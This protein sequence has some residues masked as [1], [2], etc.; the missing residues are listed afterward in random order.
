MAASIT[1]MTPSAGSPYGGQ[2]LTITGTGFGSTQGTGTITVG[3]LSAPVVSWTATEVKATTP[4]RI[5]GDGKLVTT[6]GSVSVVLTGN[7]TA[8]ASTTYTYPRTRVEVALEAITAH[9]AGCTV[10]KGYFHTIGTDQVRTMKEDVLLDWG[11]VWPQ[12]L[13]FCEGGD[14]PTD[15]HDTPFDSIKDQIQVIVQAAKPCD[16]PQAWRNEAMML[17]SDIR[18]S[19]LRAR[20]NNLSSNTTAVTAW[21]IGRISEYAEGSLAGASVTFAIEVQSIVNDMTTNTLF[22][23]NIQ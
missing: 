15:S 14:V 21:E 16:D 17:V 7:D 18:R 2:V 20:D 6:G 1:S 8:T 3:G 23:A 5:D 12:V 19:V 11:G 22:D 10:Q 4:R 13:V 9:I